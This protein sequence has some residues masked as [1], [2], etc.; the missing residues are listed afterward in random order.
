MLLL[1]GWKVLDSDNSQYWHMAAHFTIFVQIFKIVAT[2]LL[3]ESEVQPQHIFSYKS[4]LQQSAVYNTLDG[5]SCMS[6][7]LFPT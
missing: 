7:S 5:C 2:I 3:K 6:L 1:A 4:T